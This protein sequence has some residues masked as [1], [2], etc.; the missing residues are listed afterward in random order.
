MTIF[1]YSNFAIVETIGKDAKK[2]LQGQATADLNKLT[3]KNDTLLTAFCNLK[4]RILSLCFVKYISDEKILFSVEKS[5][6]KDLLAWF[7]KYSMFSK[8]T[9]TQSN[10][11]HLFLDDK[12]FLN[13]TISNEN[14][15]NTISFEEANNINILNKLP[16]INV[17]NFEK[18]L[19]AELEL[20][21]LD[22]VVVYNKGCYMGQEVIA[23]MKYRA[24]SKK[25]LA[26]VKSENEIETLDLRDENN[27]PLAI[28]VNK[29]KL[30]NENTFLV[31]F[32][33]KQ[34]TNEFILNNGQ[35]IS[36]C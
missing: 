24:V 7:K 36:K 18:F 13:H 2:F 34:E 29:N 11:F 35:I 23:R 3:N 33:K 5:V 9:F 28:I 20:D 4:G 26:I 21:N 27:K 16:T 30:Q 22:N 14:I 17:D 15:D 6:L 10:E 12:G 32:H 1:K 8:V 25:E 31:V 19:P